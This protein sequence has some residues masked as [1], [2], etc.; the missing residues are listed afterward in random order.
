MSKMIMRKHEFLCIFQ[1][2]RERPGNKHILGDLC[3]LS[4]VMLGVPLGT[5]GKEPGLGKCQGCLCAGNIC[6]S[7][8]LGS[9]NLAPNSSTGTDLSK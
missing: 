8:S 4:C 3:E 1:Q 5:P 2:Q 7:W 6:A 9:V